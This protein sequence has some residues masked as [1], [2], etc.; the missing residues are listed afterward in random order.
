MWKEYH[1]LISVYLKW[2]EIVA[3]RNRYKIGR[4]AADKGGN[5]R[6]T[7]TLQERRECPALFPYGQV[8]VF[9]FFSFHFF[10]N[11]FF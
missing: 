5:N 9:F 2:F 3:R 8:L 6:N 11:I 10:L 1:S 7:M 4:K